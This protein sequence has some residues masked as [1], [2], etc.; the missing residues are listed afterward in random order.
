MQ[1]T[2]VWPQDNLPSLM[3]GFDTSMTLQCIQK[4]GSLSS[5]FVRNASKAPLKSG[6]FWLIAHAR[7]ITRSGKPVIKGAIKGIVKNDNIYIDL[8]CS[9]DRAGRFMFGELKKLSKVMGKR[10]VTLSS[11][12]TARKAYER[13]GFRYLR[14]NKRGRP[15]MTRA[16]GLYNMRRSQSKSVSKSKSMSKSASATRKSTKTLRP[17]TRVIKKRTVRR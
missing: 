5:L 13:W 2:Y 14:K 17:R 3:R 1:T 11:V 12:P 7:G 9:K 6:E 8:I 16:S 10:A 15:L 4:G